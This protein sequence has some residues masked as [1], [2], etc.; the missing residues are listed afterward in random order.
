MMTTSSTTQTSSPMIFRTERSLSPG[1]EE[2]L[3]VI[4]KD[5]MRA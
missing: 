5:Y 2:M 4:A 3:R 1:L